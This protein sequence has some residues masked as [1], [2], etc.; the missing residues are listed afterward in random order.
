MKRLD[1]LPIP[2]IP[3]PLVQPLP[4]LVPNPTSKPDVII[5]ISEHQVSWGRNNRKL[6]HL[7]DRQLLGQR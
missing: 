1:N 6:Q 7:L 4:I 5:K 3:C 2:Q